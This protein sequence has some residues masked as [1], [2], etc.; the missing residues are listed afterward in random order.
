MAIHV[1][2]PGGAVSDRS[3]G[4]LGHLL[5]PEALANYLDVPLASIYR[6]RVR[7]YGPRGL[8][9]GKHVRY[10]LSDVEHWLD[11]LAGEH[12]SGCGRGEDTP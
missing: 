2:E 8:R 6:W 10:R 7:G 12:L 1:H 5:S 11:E 9:V 4:R 3:V